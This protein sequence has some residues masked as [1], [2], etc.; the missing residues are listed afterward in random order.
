MTSKID[1]KENCFEDKPYGLPFTNA[2]KRNA[3][4]R[5][6]LHPYGRDMSYRQ[7]AKHVG[8][9]PKTVGRVRRELEAAGVFRKFDVPV[10]T[11]QEVKHG[12]QN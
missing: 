11:T 7:I 4:K 9:D 5:A 10:Q 1:P 12:D 6:L 8:V 3:V 2:D